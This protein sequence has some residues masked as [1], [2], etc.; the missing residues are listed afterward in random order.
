[1]LISSMTDRLESVWTI[2]SIDSATGD[3][4]FPMGAY[5]TSVTSAQRFYDTV[6]LRP[7]T[8]FSSNP[9]LAVSFC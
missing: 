1:M 6:N 9:A 4:V 5:F 8:I 2:P 7:Q 3:V